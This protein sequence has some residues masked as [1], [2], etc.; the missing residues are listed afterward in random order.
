MICC[1]GEPCSIIL[2][3]EGV[4]QGNPLL[5]ILYGIALLPLAEKI[6]DKVPGML[7]AWYA[8]NTANGGWVENQAWQR[9]MTLLKR[10]GPLQGYFSYQTREEDH[11]F[12]TR[13]SGGARSILGEFTFWYKEGHH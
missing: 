2:C 10:Y 6:Q 8:D 5:K 11:H 9:G 3:R 1:I 4:T 7:Q 13:V 12:A